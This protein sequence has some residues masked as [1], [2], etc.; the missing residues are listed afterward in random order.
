MPAAGQRAIEKI[1]S[2]VYYHTT[3]SISDFNT[4]MHVLCE[5]HKMCYL[6]VDELI[7]FLLL[8]GSEGG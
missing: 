8:E 7:T 6:S 5:S 1:H 4:H 2:T 3:T